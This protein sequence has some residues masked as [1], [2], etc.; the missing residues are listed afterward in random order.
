MSGA[1]D[2]CEVT[3]AHEMSVRRIYESPRVT[4]PYSDEQWQRIERVGHHIDS[5]LKAG[6]VRLTMGGEPTFVSID[7]M[8]GDE[9][10][11]TALGD[12]KRRLA[13]ALV[14]R[15]KD[16][17]AP[18]A[19]L[20]FGQG[21]WYPGESLP[22]WALGC[23][24]RRDGVPI[25]VNEKLIADDTV[26]YGYGDAHANKFITALVDV[27]GVDAAHVIPAYEDV[28]HYL[29]AER[30]LPVNVD[31]FKSQLKNEEDRARLAR[32][33]EQGLDKV[34]GYVLP[35]KRRDESRASHMGER[36]VVRALR[37]SLPHPRRF[38]DRIS[39]AARLAAVDRAE[40]GRDDVRGRPVRAARTACGAAASAAASACG[41][42]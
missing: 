16:R 37:A 38:S 12:D 18:G 28:W 20:H 3:F 2:E 24:W 11:F 22:R 33:F 21:K 23:W 17:F 27:L 7:D 30:R 4:K 10:N 13:G 41:A 8:D 32:V 31:P 1:V 6:D 34:I 9:W 36:T 29:L 39:T 25:W 19:L 5:V 40:R 42:R 26:D 15:L 35:I 14:R